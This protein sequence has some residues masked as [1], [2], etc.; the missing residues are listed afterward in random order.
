[1]AS[2]DAWRFEDDDLAQV[3]GADFF[4]FVHRLGDDGC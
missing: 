1:M 4:R 3:A 2:D